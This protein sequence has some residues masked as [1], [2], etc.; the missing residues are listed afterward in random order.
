MAK[1]MHRSAITGRIVKVSTW[2][3]HPRTTIMRTIRRRGRQRA[4][5]S[6]GRSVGSNFH[7]MG[8]HWRAGQMTFRQLHL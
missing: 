8:T 6:S 5:R 3:R 1:V 2:Q 4:S 7:P